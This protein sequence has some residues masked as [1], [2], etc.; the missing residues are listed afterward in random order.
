VRVLGLGLLVG[1]L[2]SI[3][4]EMGGTKRKHETTLA[5]RQTLDLFGRG[6]PTANSAN[7]WGIGVI[8]KHH[9]S[10]NAQ[11]FLGGNSFPT[12]IEK[13]EAALVRKLIRLKIISPLRLTPRQSRGG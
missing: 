9:P 2:H 5:R 1:I 7:L 10:V 4:G 8:Q 11:L 6:G 3:Q 13:H 12:E